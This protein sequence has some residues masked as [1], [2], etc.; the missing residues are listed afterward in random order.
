MANT[1]SELPAVIA[2]AVA[3][4]PDTAIPLITTSLVA[5]SSSILVSWPVSMLTPASVT[6]IV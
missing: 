2:K 1:P 4:S 6:V 5:A 3:V